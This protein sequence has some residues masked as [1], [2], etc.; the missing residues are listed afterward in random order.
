VIDGDTM[1]AAAGGEHRTLGGLATVVWVALEEPADTGALSDRITEWW[2][3]SSVDAA[4]LDDAI[5]QLATHGVIEPAD[6][7]AT[8]DD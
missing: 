8:V 7:T 6:V 4:A 5:A 1:L 3:E 2:P